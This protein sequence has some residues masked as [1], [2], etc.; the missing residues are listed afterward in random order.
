MGFSFNFKGILTDWVF[1]VSK[2]KQ[3]CPGAA[4]QTAHSERSNISIYAGGSNLHS[5]GW[6][7]YRAINWMVIDL[8]YECKLKQQEVKSAHQP[9]LT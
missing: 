6:S 3:G 1:V 7:A 4:N 9:T 2:K 8:N 5:D